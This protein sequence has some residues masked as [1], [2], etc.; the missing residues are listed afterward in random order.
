MAQINLSLGDL[1]EQA[2][3]Y[4]SDA[5]E[6]TIKGVSGN[7]AGNRVAY[8][9]LGTPYYGTDEY[10]GREY[11][12]PVTIKYSPDLVAIGTGSNLTGPGGIAVNSDNGYIT[13]PEVTVILPNPVIRCERTK[14]I[15]ATN[16]TEVDGD[17]AEF[18]NKNN[19]EI[20]IRGLMVGAGNDYPEDIFA[21]IVKLEDYDGAVQIENVITDYLLVKPDRSGSNNVV[22]TSITY[23]EIP[24]VK[25]V[26]PYEVRLKSDRAFNLNI[27]TNG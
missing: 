15:I 23:P 5:F 6:P 13:G 3:G 21:K 24:G 27:I 14:R 7:T 10:T 11:F 9:R 16:L 4:R 20:T 1:F 25:H 8:S 2:F 18:I 17:F 26:K 22:I 19:W 12:M